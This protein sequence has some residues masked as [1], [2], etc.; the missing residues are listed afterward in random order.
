MENE[1]FTYS[2]LTSEQAIKYFADVDYNLKNGRH[3]QDF[4]TDHKLFSYLEEFY[5]KGLKEYY[6]DL[7]GMLLVCED[8]DQERYYYLDFPENGKGKL[9]RENRSKELED[10][11]LIFAILLL[12][13]YK[14]KFFEK[15]EIKWA[16]LEQVFKESEHKDIWQTWLYVKVK[17][18]YSP[19][20]ETA[21]IN[22]IIKILKSFEDLGW[23]NIINTEPMHFEIL[24][25]INR[26]SHMY[27]EIIED[28]DN[29]KQYLNYDTVS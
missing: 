4:G 11:H 10:S 29:I 12:N 19:N 5:D 28:V 7:F 2:F 25:A 15:K 16:E 27:R 1:D 23:V 9:G 13:L 24:P 17:N 26:I 6:A 22:K 8:A 21:A 18:N 20:E 3:I 14:E